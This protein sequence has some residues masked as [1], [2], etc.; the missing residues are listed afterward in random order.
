[1]ISQFNVR[2]NV[3]THLRAGQTGGV[4][5]V[6]GTGETSTHFDDCD[7]ILRVEVIVVR[8]VDDLCDGQPLLIRVQRSWLSK[9]RRIY[10][11]LTSTGDFQTGKTIKPCYCKIMIIERNLLIPE[12]ETVGSAD[13]DDGVTADE[14]RST[15]V[16]SVIA[17]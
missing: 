4:D 17:V 8:V 10:H 12:L 5:R 11:L 15:T 2:R 13:D 7:V 3:G 6:R 1:M 14:G 9:I 16:P